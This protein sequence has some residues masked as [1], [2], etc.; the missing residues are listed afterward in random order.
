MYLDD[1][2]QEQAIRAGV[3][4]RLDPNVVTNLKDIYDIA[5]RKDGYGPAMIFY[6][7]GIAY[8]TQKYAEAGIAAPVSWADLWDPRLAGKVIA[9]DLSVAMGRDFLIAAA[10]YGGRRRK[11]IGQRHRQNRESQGSVLPLLVCH[12]RGVDEGR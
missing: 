10:R 1:I 8:N 9:P 6:S 7:I 3:L 4:D 2:I 11:F 5:K 12:D